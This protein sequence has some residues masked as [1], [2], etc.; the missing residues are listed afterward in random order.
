MEIT[1]P[2]FKDGGDIPTKYA[3]D[4]ENIN[5]PLVFSDIPV[6]TVSLLLKVEDPDAPGGT[7]LHWLIFDIPPEIG[8]IKENSR[9][10]DS[11]AGINDS[12]LTDY[13][14]PCPPEGTHRYIF[15]INAL[16]IMLDLPEGET[17]REV[18][19]WT[20]G[21]IIDSAELIGLYKKN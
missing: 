5:P 18:N 20:D 6:G 13:N 14:G 10:D 3:C 7:F 19:N 15:T 1:S 8:E 16:D 4:G 9:P 12:G 2:V 21:H 17:K 11:R